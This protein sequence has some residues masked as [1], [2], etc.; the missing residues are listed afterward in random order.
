MTFQ[1]NDNF[2]N[3]ELSIEELDMIAAG[4]LWGD[5]TGVASAIGSAASSV[6]SSIA[7]VA[8]DIY[9]Q[10]YLFLADKRSVVYAAGAPHRSAR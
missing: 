6:A 8:E 10:G 3:R 2:A 7:G 4:G 5:I 1:T 9:H